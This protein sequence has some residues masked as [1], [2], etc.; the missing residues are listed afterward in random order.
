MPSAGELAANDASEHS[1]DGDQSR[2]DATVHDR[3]D[4]TE[5]DRTLAIERERSTGWEAALAEAHSRIEEG[6]ARFRDAQREADTLR[7]ER[8][9]ARV[10][11]EDARRR[12]EEAER[13]QA[14]A[15]ARVDQLRAAWW[16]WHSLATS[17]PWWRRMRGLPVTP[18]EL[19]TPPLLAAPKG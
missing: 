3:T 19:E 18:P 1:V 16:R 5:R 12:A 2:Q 6:L 8:D 13:G 10:V 15:L 7:S 4:A 9:A 14:A 17:W 11:A